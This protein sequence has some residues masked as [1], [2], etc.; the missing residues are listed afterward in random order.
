MCVFVC[1]CAYTCVF[2]CVCIRVCSYVY[3]H[4]CQVCLCVCM[5]AILGIHVNDLEQ[6][7]YGTAQL[8]LGFTHTWKLHNSTCF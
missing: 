8:K 2:V 1:M 7:I 6:G 3:I 4:V 5:H